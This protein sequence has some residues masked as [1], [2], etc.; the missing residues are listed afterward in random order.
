MAC[1]HPIPAYLDKDGSVKFERKDK[2]IGRSGFIHLPCGM[3]FGCK[4]D[5]AREWAIRSYHESQLH[6]GN[7]FIT[8]TYAPSKLPPHGTLDPKDLRLFFKR[9]RK[10]GYTFR[11]FACGEYGDERLRPHYH[12]CMFGYLPERNGIAA[13]SASGHIQFV[14]DE[15][16][17]AWGLGRVTFT[18]FH[19]DAARYTAHYTSKKLKSFAKDEVD[20]ETGLKP[21]ERKEPTGEIIQLVPE[22]QR[23][24]NKP[25]L[26]IPWL[27][28]NWREV[29]P[30]DSVVMDGREYPPPKAYWKWL[31]E[32]QVDV[33]ETIKKK[34]LAS[35]ATRP[36]LTG[37][38]LEQIRE[39]QERS[40]SN[41]VRPF[42][43]ETNDS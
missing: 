23:S 3:C 28:K 4:A 11:Y 31:K 26:G 1:H 12:A 38:R 27:K 20:P 17:Q 32:N 41:L 6:R 40:I 36:Y 33:Y 37:Q 5:R 30:A 13:K 35:I 16:T 25:G 14:N 8:L 15:L 18:E 21:Y 2:A 43:G 42:T 7:S 24:S 19:S 9:L 34:R 39:C 10:R 29:F 22:F